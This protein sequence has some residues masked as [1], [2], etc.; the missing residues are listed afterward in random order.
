LP[1]ANFYRA[2]FE[3]IAKLSLTRLQ[4]LLHTFAVPS[5]LLSRVN[6]DSACP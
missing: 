1:I 4:G 5:Y 6:G 3:N 2:G